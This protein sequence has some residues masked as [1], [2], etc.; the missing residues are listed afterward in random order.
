MDIF[1]SEGS[2][3]SLTGDKWP[4]S[5]LLDILTNQ[6]P[7]GT[8]SKNHF[9]S[10]PASGFSP[11]TSDIHLIWRRGNF[12]KRVHD[13]ALAKWRLHRC[14][15]TAASCYR[16]SVKMEQYAARLLTVVTLFMLQQRDQILSMRTK[17]DARTEPEETRRRGRI[18][19]QFPGEW[20]TVEYLWVME[21][22][23]WCRLCNFPWSDVKF[24]RWRHRFLHLFILIYSFNS[25]NILTYQVIV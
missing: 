19:S 14:L 16:I 22:N 3:A 23:F 17:G 20:I 4:F 15:V 2:V 25:G 13:T 21:L 12:L 7:L 5:S 1:Y 11:H 18:L 10:Q 9:E 24:L 8:H 6:Q